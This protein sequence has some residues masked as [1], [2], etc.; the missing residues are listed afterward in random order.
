[1]SVRTGAVGVLVP[2]VLDG[3]IG[4]CRLNPPGRA[5]VEERRAVLAAAWVVLTCHS[6]LV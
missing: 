5:T 3:R 4:S 6:S 1:M 2:F